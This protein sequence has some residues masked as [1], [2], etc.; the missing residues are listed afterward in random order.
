MPVFH[1][2]SLGTIWHGDSLKLLRRLKPA[3]VDLIVTSPPFALISQKEYGNRTGSDYLAWLRRFAAQWYRVLK[4]SGS[5]AIDLGGAW[6]PGEPTR[7]LY[8]WKVLLMLVED[9]GFSLCQD[10]YWYNPASMPAPAEWVTIRRIRQKQAVNT[11]WW[12][13]KT[14]WPKA[15][16]TRTLWPF[17][18][19]MERF[20]ATEEWKNRGESRPSGHVPIFKPGTSGQE[21][22]AIS[23]NLISCANTESSSAYLAGCAAADLKPHPARFPS[24]IPEF[25]VRLCTDVGDVV[26]DPFGGSCTTGEVCERLGRQWVCCER[27]RVYLEGALHRFPAG[28]KAKLK[29]LFAEDADDL[30]RQTPPSYYKVYRPGFGW[31]HVPFKP[32]DR[33]G[34]KTRTVRRNKK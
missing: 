4:P 29:P 25:F 2:T 22:G 30:S 14:A 19:S 13:G 23:P 34:G 33:S 28:K 18:A 15:S 21:N 3:S 12:L 24:E 6:N 8:Q 7:S 31:A 27:K 16:N 26:L 1:T 17:S 11:I 32:L 20:V 5:L 9:I 10:F